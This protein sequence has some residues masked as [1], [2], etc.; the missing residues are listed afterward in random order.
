MLRFAPVLL[1][2]L[3]TTG[4]AAGQRPYTP[5]SPFGAD[6][7]LKPRKGRA[8]G[9]TIQGEL[10]AVSP[11]SLWLLQSSTTIA[12][13][14]AEVGGVQMRRFHSGASAALIWGLVGGLVSGGLLTA[15]CATV[16]DASCGGVMAF[17]LITWGLWG[18]IGAATL[19][20]SSTRTLPPSEGAL[21][22]YA[23]FPQGLPGDLER[24]TFRLGVRAPLPQ[25]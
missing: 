24:R 2:S 9:P 15:A 4:T 23:R 1:L 6:V 14:L 17:S 18:G 12:V 10:I 11:D 22:G 16:E 7:V 3:A 20:S 5:G 19:G 21:R 8:A 13:P 25:P